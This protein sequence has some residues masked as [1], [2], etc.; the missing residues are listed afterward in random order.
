MRCM[1]GKILDKVS[2][3]SEGQKVHLGKI[4]QNIMAKKEVIQGQISP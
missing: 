3:A 2:Y 1:W 4:F